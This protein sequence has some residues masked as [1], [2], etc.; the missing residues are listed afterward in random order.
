MRKMEA[1]L[2]MAVL[3][4][5]LMGAAFLLG[6]YLNRR[7]VA[8]SELS[9][10]TRQ[11]IDLFQ[12][13]QLNERAVESTKARFRELLERGEVAAVEA[14]L[15]PGVSYVVQVR[16]LA[17]L[18][19]EQAGLILER[20]L[21]RRLTNDQL[22]QS[23]YLI[24]LANGLR[25]LNR[26][27][28]LPHLL[29]CAESAGDIPLSHFFAAETICFLGFAGYLGQPETRL[30]RAALQVLH[31]ALE[32]LRLGVPPQLIAEAR[33]GEVIE[34][35]WDHQPKQAHSLVV[36]VLYEAQR[37]LRRAPQARSALAEEGIEQEAFDWQMSRLAALQCV[38]ADF[39]KQ[40]P[41]EL[42][43]ALPTA[44]GPEQRNILHALSDLHAEAA[45]VLLPL[46]DRP[47]FP[48]ADL[49]A[50]VLTW[51]RADYVGPWLRAWAA[52]R[53]PIDR[54]ALHRP[55]ALPP[56]RRSVP[57]DF[58]Y[59]GVLRAL[60]GHPSGETELFLLV[61][62]RDWDPTYRAAAVSSLGWWEPLH[63]TE[64]RLA[65]QQARRDANGD[66]RL[67]ARAAL[68]RLGERQALLGFR[69]ALLGEDAQHVYETLQLVVA[70]GLTLLWPD[71]DKLADADD[72]DIAQQAREALERLAEDM[73]RPRA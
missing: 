37:L 26:E 27:E 17:E 10:V 58:P 28:S 43:R 20:Q 49:A 38:V 34:S 3:L 36:R 25:N 4:P 63:G 46:L 61:A 22:E 66:V 70:E 68:A 14:S 31:G 24:D 50:E 23:W 42:C 12:G 57:A 15:R 5:V 16:A 41:T 35:L 29:R 21:N 44:P 33:L 32:G 48:H 59:Q 51:S 60:R 71:V 1:V 67:A 6:R 45:P 47:S 65:L 19:T 7:P 64:V 52:R 13:G 62:A 72:R 2:I 55:R 11:H 40:A 54:R 73:D 18:G 69:Q 56:R 9:A 8:G 30:G 53:V 39:L